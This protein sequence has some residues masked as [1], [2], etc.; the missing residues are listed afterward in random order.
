MTIKL[1]RR[2]YTRKDGT[3]VKAVYKKT[4]W[5]QSVNKGMKKRGTVGVFTK[6]KLNAGYPN[7]PA[8]TVKFAN[9]VL[10]GKIAGKNTALW[11]DRA[12]LAKAF[13]RISRKR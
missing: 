11:H 7:T 8:G 9:A 12:G 3:R 4:G 6:A 2:A 5:M 1:V 13:V 10:A